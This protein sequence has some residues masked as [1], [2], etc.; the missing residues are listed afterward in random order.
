MTIQEE[1][2]YTMG[3][4]EHE[5]QRLIEQSHLYEN[6]TLRFFE[7]AGIDNGMKV[8]DIGSGA[9]DV[10]MAA[11]K[12][13]GIEGQVIG[14]DMNPDIVESANSRAK[15]DGFTNIEF[16]AGDI[17]AMELDHDFDAVIGRLVLM[18]LKQPEATLKRLASHVKPGGIVAF[19]EAELRTYL[20]LKREDTPF[21]NDL[22]DWGL[23][24]FQRTGANIGMGFE[25][26]NTFEKAG[27]PEPTLR[28]EA[29]MGCHPSWVG[30]DFLAASFKSLLPLIISLE[31]ATAEQIDI[32][33]L[34]DRLRA[35]VATSK[36]PM[37]LPPHV[38]AYSVLPD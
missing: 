4:S 37:L 38:M 20:A 13:V 29:P 33:T 26:F 21:A 31:I 2:T 25:I 7:S 9:G 16:R 3:R 14:V 5:R 32:D 10:A 18:Y 23:E 6:I 1:Q 17:D 30:F 22:I 36:I 8:L 24:V 15:A 27:L 28:Y 35:E 11:A 12:L 34:A 19:Q